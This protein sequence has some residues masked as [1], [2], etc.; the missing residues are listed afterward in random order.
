MERVGTARQFSQVRWV[1][2]GPEGG[3]RGSTRGQCHMTLDVADQLVSEASYTRLMRGVR[4][5]VHCPTNC[6]HLRVIHKHRSMY[7]EPLKRS[8]GKALKCPATRLETFPTT[9]HLGSIPDDLSEPLEVSPFS[10]HTALSSRGSGDRAKGDIGGFR[11][12]SG[13]FA[14]AGRYWN[15]RLVVSS[16]EYCAQG[17]GDRSHDCKCLFVWSTV[18]CCEYSI[19][20]DNFGLRRPA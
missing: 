12:R 1:A 9:Q 20:I 11:L 8:C 13:S 3:G 14:G 10:L 7:N 16:A 6:D 15:A 19:R 4:G 5:C 17:W 18:C 2:R